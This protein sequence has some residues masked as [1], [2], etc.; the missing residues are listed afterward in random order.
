LT[1]VANLHR[2]DQASW[3]TDEGTLQF[4]AGMGVRPAEVYLPPEPRFRAQ[5]PSWAK[6]RYREVVESFQAIGVKP[7]VLAGAS[8]L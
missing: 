7:V 5:A 8:V 2:G 3:R 6:E 4:H 1:G